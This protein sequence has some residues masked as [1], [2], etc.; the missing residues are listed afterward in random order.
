MPA[1]IEIIRL[2]ACDGA[3][4]NASYLPAQHHVANNLRVGVVLVQE[5]FGVNAHIRWLLQQYAE[6]GIAVIAPHFFDRV[7][8][9]VQLDYG[10]DGF[11]KGR[12]IVGQLGFDA[13]MRD[14]RAAANWLMSLASVS[15]VGI[16]GYCWGGT[17]AALSASRLALPSVGYYGA[18]THL[19]VHETLQAP[20]Q[21]HF[22]T[23]DPAIP[24]AN[25]QLIGESWPHADIHRYDAG[26]GFNRFGHADYQAACATLAFARSKAFLLGNVL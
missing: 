8:A 17:V 9:D 26:H 7:N 20:L 22:G 16:V 2:R 10:P 14:V 25:V 6:A 21:L 19:F 3:E 11:A 15:R 13:P 4:I 18:R 1:N 24:D 5:I 23:Q 12:E